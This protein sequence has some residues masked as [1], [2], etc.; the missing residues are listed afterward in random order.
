MTE[1]EFFW[2]VDRVCECLR[3]DQN[4]DRG[5]IYTGERSRVDA[6]ALPRSSELEDYRSRRQLA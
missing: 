1:L 3:R 6:A 2:Y 5:S 4:D